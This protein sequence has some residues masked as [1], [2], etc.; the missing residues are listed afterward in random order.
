MATAWRPWTTTAAPLHCTASPL[1]T[2]VPRTQPH[3]RRSRA[4]LTAYPPSKRS[5]QGSS[6]SAWP[7]DNSSHHPTTSTMPPNSNS[8]IT[9]TAGTT[10]EA[11][12]AAAT[13]AMVAATGNNQPRTKANKVVA[14]GLCV[15]PRPTSNGRIGTIAICMAVMSKK[16]TQA[17]CA[18]DK[19]PSTTRMPCMPT[20]WVAHQR[21][22][23]RRFYLLHPA[24][25]HLP[26]ANSNNSSNVLLS[27]TTPCRIL[28]G[29]HL[30]G[31]TGSGSPWQCPLLSKALP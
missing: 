22:C 19:A 12:A 26:P 20:P 1:Q 4:K 23:T 24:V 9:T 14:M 5:W 10:V 6:S 29:S 8:V 28:H 31:S 7:L 18:P 15:P 25:P 30:L 3:K 16:P 17:P 27:P 21:G 13:T 11:E 2:S